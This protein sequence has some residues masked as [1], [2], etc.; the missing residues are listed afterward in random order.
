[1]LAFVGSVPRQI[2]RDKGGV[3]RPTGTSGSRGSS[4]TSRWRAVSATIRGRFVRLSLECAGT[5]VLCGVLCEDPVTRKNEADSGA[6]ADAAVDLQPTAV[7]LQQLF[8]E[9]QSEPRAVEA[10][11]E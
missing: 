7:Q 11:G 4:P 10:T 5:S 1:M 8:G 6:C 3:L 2:T 9:R